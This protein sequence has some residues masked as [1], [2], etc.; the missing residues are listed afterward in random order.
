MEQKI[1]IIANNREL[2]QRIE[3]LYREDVRQGRILIEILDFEKI[4]EQGRLLEKRGAKVIIARSGGYRHTLGKVSVP[5]IQFKI[6]TLDILAAI[7]SAQKISRHVVLVISDL[8]SFAYEEWREM[9]Q[10]RVT[11][12]EFASLEAIED[13]VFKYAAAP[14]EV[15][16]VGG[17]IPCRFARKFGLKYVPISAGKESIN[18]IMTSAWELVDNLYEQKYKN[19][20]LKK[21]LDGVHDAVLAVD[22]EGRIIHCN[23]KVKATLKGERNPLIGERLDQVFPE[24]GFMVKGSGNKANEIINLNGLVIT[25]NTSRLEVDGQVRGMLCSFQ[26]IT[27]LQN[28]EKKIRYELNKKGL[29]AKY[30]FD[31][32]I[33]WD[34]V[35]KGTVAKGIKIGLTDVTVMIYGESGTGKEMFAQSM[36]NISARKDEPF[37]A[38]NCAAI[39]ESLLESELFGYEEGAF[40]GARKGGKPGLFE[41]A[42]GGTVFLDEINSVSPALQ[43]KLLRVL[44]EKELMRIG[45]DYVIPLDVRIISAAN[46]SLLMK[47]EEGNFRRDLFYRLSILELKI[48]PLREREMD[49]VPIFK[50]YL[51]NLEGASGLIIDD[52]LAEA[53]KAYTW[54]G[55]VRELRNNA[56][57]YAIFGEL[58]INPGPWPK[59]TEFLQE[60]FIDLKE[61]NRYV[62]TKVIDLLME[63][64]LSK[65][66][67]A[68]RLGISR[69]SLWNKSNKRLNKKEDR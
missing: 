27:K 3:E 33:A 12:E 47:M 66:E 59:N 31:D 62:E 55:N 32:L 43:A 58:D 69:A 35:M 13:K 57:R 4:E 6:N 53:L 10:A 38:I 29:R 39:S 61:I 65:N 18:E 37:V 68:K 41:L 11:I 8:E 2:K 28:L 30:H 36:H 20:V 64:G 14:A 22:Q 17:G 44:E 7:K 15:V 9:I 23:E 25:A 16:I 46:E 40:T 56:Q 34:P 5:V 49:I 51:S 24:L 50:H 19:E 45:S 21:T 52:E 67:I 26:D 1:G 54:P 63:K 48:P 42:H 60:G